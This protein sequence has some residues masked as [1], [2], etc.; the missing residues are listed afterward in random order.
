[1]K[2]PTKSALELGS[3]QGPL[4]KATC[5]DLLLWAKQKQCRWFVCL[6][7]D[8]AADGGENK[9]KPTKNGSFFLLSLFIHTIN[10][11]VSVGGDRNR[12]GKYSYD[13]NDSQ[14]SSVTWLATLWPAAGGAKGSQS[15][16]ILQSG[17][18]H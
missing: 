3:H 9:T 6:S 16:L 4:L 15:W 18:C 5:S 2:G 13:I 11:H 17:M 10:T 1:M 8:A 7:V 14:G 12:F